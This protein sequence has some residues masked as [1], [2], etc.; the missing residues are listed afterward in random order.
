MSNKCARTSGWNTYIPEEGDS[1]S[2][3]LRHVAHHCGCRETDGN[4]NHAACLTW[5]T[6]KFEHLS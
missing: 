3:I 1:Q 2:L 6:D 5:Q 4:A